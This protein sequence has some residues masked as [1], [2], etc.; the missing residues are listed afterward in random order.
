[1][2]MYHFRFI[3]SFVLALFLTSICIVLVAWACD[4]DKLKRKVETYETLIEN[5]R[6]KITRLEERGYLAAMTQNGWYGM[7]VGVAVGTATAAS[8]GPLAP[9]TAVPVIAKGALIGSV[10]G[11]AWGGINHHKELSAARD[12]LE[13]L[14]SQKAE[15][16][17]DYEACANPPAKYTYT[18]E[19]DYVWEFSAEVY[20][21]DEAAYDAYMNFIA[22]EGH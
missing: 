14:E 20:G 18:D 13:R 5:Q 6:N 2:R 8:T 10:G 7:G 16:Q 15:A 9:V 12:E 19:H 17:A 11:I 21:S 3:A 4:K 1:M 22:A